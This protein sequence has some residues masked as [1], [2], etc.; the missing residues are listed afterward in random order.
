MT[1]CQKLRF[2]I[3]NSFENS[4]PHV[5]ELL[6]MET[7]VKANI[8]S[9]QDKCAAVRKASNDLRQNSIDEETQKIRDSDEAAVKELE[10]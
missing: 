6:E 8:A 9:V 1:D 4:E 5:D 3:E 7:K 10:V 2:K